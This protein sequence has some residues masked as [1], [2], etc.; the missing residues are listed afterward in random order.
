LKE[1]VDLE[2]R[3]SHLV[4]LVTDMLNTVSPFAA[5]RWQDHFPLELK[6]KHFITIR[7]GKPE[8]SATAYPD[9]VLGLLRFVRNLQVHAHEHDLGSAETVYDFIDTHYDWFFPGWYMF[10]CSIENPHTAYNKPAVFFKT[11]ETR[12]H[13]LRLL[14]EQQGAVV[15]INK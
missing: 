14:R 12:Y 6:R 2:T 15:L 1:F 7:F 10:L 5:E 13:R 9:H 11:L 8:Y 4:S 3:T